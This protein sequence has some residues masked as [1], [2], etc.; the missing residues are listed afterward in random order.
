M[1]YNILLTFLTVQVGLFL[2]GFDYE[3]GLRLVLVNYPHLKTTLFSNFQIN[4]AT[5]IDDKL[6]HPSGHLSLFDK[7][8]RKK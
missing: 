2:F 1:A 7:K 3:Q 8:S 6:W 5:L 4:I